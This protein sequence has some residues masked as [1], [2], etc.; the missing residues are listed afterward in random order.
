[1][2]LLIFLFV[3]PLNAQD[4]PQ[5]TVEQG[6]IIG[7][8]ALDGDYLTFYGIH[9]GGSTAG[10]NR[11]KVNRS[12]YLYYYVTILIRFIVEACIKFVFF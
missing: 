3:L 12:V 2:W 1:M 6:V 10:A 7:S 5:V 11:F 9:Y 8:R 4:A